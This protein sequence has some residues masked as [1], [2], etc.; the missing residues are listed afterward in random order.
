MNS[1]KEKIKYYREKNNISKSE[2]SRKIGVS[3][4]YI[5]ML[6]NG[7][8]TN[9]SLEIK[10]KLANALNCSV[11]DLENTI[12]ISE[13]LYKIVNKKYYN[14]ISGDEIGNLLNLKKNSFNVESFKNA[15][16]EE[17]EKFINDLA[18][19]DPLSLKL[20]KHINN[21]D[22][23]TKEDLINITKELHQYGND[24]VNCFIENYHQPKVRELSNQLNQS[25]ELLHEY[26][27][28]VKDKDKIIDIYKS[29]IDEINKILNKFDK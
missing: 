5:T 20:Q 19:I 14:S 1:L 4:S 11:D 9:P 2:L 21:F 17:K 23:F 24:L 10:I 8:K 27:D 28:V 22:N 29:K 16:K 6:E 18:S 3:P 15:T 7:E 25:M 13:E 26:N 12:D